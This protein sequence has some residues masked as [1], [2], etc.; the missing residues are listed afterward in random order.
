MGYFP[1]ST[2]NDI[3]V[4]DYCENCEYNP[5]LED[6]LPCICMTMHFLFNY[7]ECNKKDSLLHKMIPLDENGFNGACTFYTPISKEE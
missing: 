4:V 3:Y 2:A 1:N 7:N 6:D 5:I